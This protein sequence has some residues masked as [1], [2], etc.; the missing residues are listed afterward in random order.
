MPLVPGKNAIRIRSVDLAGNRSA[1]AT[2]Y[3]TY[4]I[5]GVLEV[6]IN[7]TGS[8][9][10]DL[11]GRTLEL[12]KTYSVTAKPARGQIF[13]GW[14]N[15]GSIT[16][17]PKISFL[18]TSNLVLV[19]NFVANPFET[20]T[21]QYVGLFFDGDTNRFRPENS[22]K[23]TLMLSLNGGFTG[24]LNL[25]GAAY[26]FRGQFDPS[27]DAKVPI[28]R[29]GLFPLSMS[30]HLDSAGTNQLTGTVVTASDV[31]RLTSPLQAFRVGLTAGSNLPGS[32]G[33]R[34]QEAGVDQNVGTGKLV[35]SAKGTVNVSGKVDGRTF[36]AS[37]GMNDT[38]QVP[39]YLSFEHGTE[40]F[41]GWFDVSPESG[42]SGTII[43][44]IPG[45]V[46]QLDV[47]PP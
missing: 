42:V 20:L 17:N 46:T 10:P 5:S 36:A 1:L 44:S 26:N 27:G 30:L 47:L 6:Q 2:R 31:N 23:I 43:E 34:L 39:L 35:A 3:Y 19:A 9:V 28:A 45:T 29:P 16:N 11:N 24:K 32:Y 41:I 8:V 13:S 33:F 37:S 25:Q 15:A 21:G 40:I 12:G 14:Q 18:M 38:G 4:V 22:G 7:G